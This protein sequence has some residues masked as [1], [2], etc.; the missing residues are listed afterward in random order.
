VISPLL[1]N[2]HVHWFDKL[3]HRPEGPYRWANARLIRYAADFVIMARY[4][5]PRIERFVEQT[6]QGRFEL[7]INADKTRTAKLNKPGQNSAS[8]RS[9]C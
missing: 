4:V 2:L 5:G 3:F 1:A 6:L 8:S 7:K 9:P